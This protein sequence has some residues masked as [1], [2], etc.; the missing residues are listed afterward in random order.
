[1]TGREAAA[2][3]RIVGQQRRAIGEHSSKVRIIR[4]HREIVGRLFRVAQI[5]AVP[6]ARP[7]A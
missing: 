4:V 6:G 1:M 7:E 5:L 3:V 2:I